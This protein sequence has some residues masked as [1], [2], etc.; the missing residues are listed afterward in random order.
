MGEYRTLTRQ[1]LFDM[2]W[3]K[4][5]Q[6]LAHEFKISDVGF[7]KMCKRHNIPRP[8]RGHW[9]RAA[10]GKAPRKPSLP[11]DASAQVPLYIPDDPVPQPE[12]VIPPEVL[13]WIERERDHK[14][15]IVVPRTIREYHPLVQNARTALEARDNYRFFDPWRSSGRA[16]GIFIRVTKRLVGPACRIMNALLTSFEKR[17]FRIRKTHESET[18]VNI[19]GEDFRVT[20]TERTRRVAHVPT[21][22]EAERE[23]RGLGAPQKYDDVPSG[24]LR[25]DFESAGCR[26]SFDSDDFEVTGQLNEVVIALVR[27]VL[28]VI[29]PERERK[30]KEEEKRHEEEQRRWAFQ[31]KCERFDNAY[32]AWAAHQERLRFLEVIEGALAELERPAEATKEFVAWARRYVE[33]ADPMPKFFQAIEQDTHVYYHAFTRPR[34]GA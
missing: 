12:P 16:G 2:V 20:L 1:E 3:S 29:R 21:K 6:Q 18:V 23:R 27:L 11:G 5:V 32:Q 4:P 19:L 15:R 8:E 25:L 13:T 7:A 9:Q 34:F 24:R 28:E 31:Q 10:V 30:A 14:N 26:R 17:D 33:W 22:D